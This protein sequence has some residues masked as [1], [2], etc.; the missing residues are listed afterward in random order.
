MEDNQKKDEQDDAA[1]M[2]ESTDKEAEKK[3]AG[4]GL[5]TVAGN[6]YHG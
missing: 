2:V 3:P 4:S 1:K 5:F 6:K